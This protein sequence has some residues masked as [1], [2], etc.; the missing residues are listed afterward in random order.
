MPPKKELPNFDCRFSIARK[1]RKMPDVDSTNRHPAY[2]FPSN[3]RKCVPVPRTQ[4]LFFFCQCPPNRRCQIRCSHTRIDRSTR[5]F[6]FVIYVF[7]RFEA[8][9]KAALEI[10]EICRC[11]AV[12][13]NDSTTIN[14]VRVARYTDHL[15]AFVDTV[16]L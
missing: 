9:S 5:D 2:V 8:R 14:K 13:P 6:S 1:K 12:I 16:G 15:A 3:G 10:V 11:I 7:R 4:R